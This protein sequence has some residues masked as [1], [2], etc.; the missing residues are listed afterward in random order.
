MY[1]YMLKEEL[2]ENVVNQVLTRGFSY[3]KTTSIK[4]IT[5]K[6]VFRIGNLIV[7]GRIIKDVREIKNNHQVQKK[8]ILLKRG[9]ALLYYAHPMI[10]YGFARERR[11]LSLIENVFRNVQ[12]I[13]P[14]NYK[15]ADMDEYIQLVK[16]CD[17]VVFECINDVI[18]AG[19]GREVIVAMKHKIPVFQ[20]K[21][22]KE[23]IVRVKEIRNRVL[24][25]DE[26]NWLYKGLLLNPTKSTEYM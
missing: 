11:A 6:M 21:E 9:R 15:L 5:D 20:I 10:F 2:P 12:I 7:T 16:K 4:S 22:N 14:R 26:T 13:N 17:M 8:V 25:V 1:E 3:L 24:T 23:E 19:V 18:T